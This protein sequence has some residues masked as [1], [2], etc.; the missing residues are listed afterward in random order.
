MQRN[1]KNK[2]STKKMYEGD[3]LEGGDPKYEQPLFYID[4]LHQDGKTKISSARPPM[5]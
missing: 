1:I 5:F 4:L 2:K 3:P